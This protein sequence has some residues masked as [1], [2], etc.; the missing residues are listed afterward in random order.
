MRWMAFRRTKDQGAS[1]TFRSLENVNL[2]SATMPLISKRPELKVLPVKLPIA[3]APVGIVTLKNR[4]PT[5]VAR[6]F[7]DGT[8]EFARR[9]M[10]GKS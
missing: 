7:I 5:P 10:K 1:P 3:Q 6:L 4:T 2:P 9:L 8:R